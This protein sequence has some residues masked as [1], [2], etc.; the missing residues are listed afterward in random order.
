METPFLGTNLKFN[1]RRVVMQILTTC[2]IC[3]HYLII[4]QK[5]EAV[6]LI[7]YLNKWLPISVWS[8]VI[9]IT[10]DAAENAKQAIMEL[11]DEFSGKLGY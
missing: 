10:R 5:Q 7:K 3:W 2:S 4:I 6:N 8:K 9:Q 11:K 1:T